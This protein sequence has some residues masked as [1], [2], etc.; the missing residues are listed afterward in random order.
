M[1]PTLP[2]S[3]RAPLPPCTSPT[4]PHPH[5]QALAQIT[6]LAAGGGL[7]GEGGAPPHVFQSLLYLRKLCSHP[8]LVLDAEVPQHMQVGVLGGVEWP[9]GGAAKGQCV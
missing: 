7:G 9:G 1:L 4:P 6:G 8:L 3:H 2:D 5:A